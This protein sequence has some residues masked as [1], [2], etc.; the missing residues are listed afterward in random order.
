M[1]WKERFPYGALPNNE[2]DVVELS[3]DESSIGNA[4]DVEV[5]A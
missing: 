2:Y 5:I 3:A 1:V 4:I